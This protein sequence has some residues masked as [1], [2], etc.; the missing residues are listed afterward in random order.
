MNKLLFATST[1]LLASAC[2]GSAPTAEEYDDVAT[3]MSGILAEGSASETEAAEDAATAAE[4]QLPAA[5]TRAGQGTLRG[6]RGTVDYDFT[7][8]CSDAQG[9]VLGTCDQADSAHL[10]LAWNGQIETAR[11]SATVERHGD[12]TLTGL[13]TPE[14]TL[15]GTGS[16]HL[17]GTFQA[18]GR[19]E[20]RSYV[21]DY[22][23]DYQDVRIGKAERRIN[24]GQ[25]TYTISADRT[26]Q[27][28]L[29]TK[30][31]HFDVVAV[32][33]FLGNGQAHVVLDGERS[34]EVDLVAGTIR[35]NAAE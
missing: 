5:M 30:E 29:R 28:A 33:T 6:R 35:K 21:F 31:R 1:L 10:L 19:A 8:T 4:G 7:L 11:R 12:W 25:A 9:A 20:N 15:N 24:G 3:S 27:G 26:A 32:V 2:G 17:E 13:K 23:A 16:L 22:Q 14:L 18:L 34:Y